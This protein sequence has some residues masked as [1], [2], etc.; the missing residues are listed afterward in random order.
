MKISKKKLS[1][2]ANTA[3]SCYFDGKHDLNMKYK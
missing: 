3:K 2:N 1:M